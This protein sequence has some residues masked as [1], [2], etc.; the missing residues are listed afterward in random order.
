MYICITLKLIA[1]KTGIL[2]LLVFAAIPLFYALGFRVQQLAIHQ[3]M[4]KRLESQFLHSITI[5]E[6]D[7][8]WIE[9]GK[10]ILINGMMFDI[11]SST[12]EK[13]YYSFTGLYDNEDQAL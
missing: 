3:K 2:L 10:E 6:K 9:K 11:R 7:I 5:A 4:K 8:Y 12:F 1:K 13:G